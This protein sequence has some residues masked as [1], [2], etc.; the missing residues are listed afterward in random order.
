MGCLFSSAVRINP[1][2]GLRLEEK[3]GCG[4]V[5]AKAPAGPQETL[6][7]SWFFIIVLSWDERVRVAMSAS[8]WKWAA[9]G[10]GM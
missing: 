6:K 2:G 1:Y 8:H 5:S 3:L 7:L 9:S 4:V 10:E